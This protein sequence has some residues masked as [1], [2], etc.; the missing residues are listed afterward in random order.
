M[1]PLP[2]SRFVLIAREGV[3]LKEEGA[4]KEGVALKEEGASKEKAGALSEGVALVCLDRARE[5]HQPRDVET[6]PLVAVNH[7]AHYP[8]LTGTVWR[9]S[10]IALF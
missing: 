3:A 4:S 7:S 5:Y 1:V 10:D 8:L 6:E 9:D 2:L